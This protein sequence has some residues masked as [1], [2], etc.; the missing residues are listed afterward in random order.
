MADPKI[1][2]GDITYTKIDG[3]WYK[4]TGIGDSRVPIEIQ[5]PSPRTLDEIYQ[6]ET[7]G[8]AVTKTP[9]P[10][11]PAPAPSGAI[12]TTDQVDTFT[13]LIRDNPKGW[14]NFITTIKQTYPEIFG[15]IEPY[16]EE[17]KSKWSA[18][19]LATHL[20]DQEEYKKV[21][22]PDVDPASQTTKDIIILADP[23]KNNF[24][25]QVEAYLGNF[26]KLITRVGNFA[27]N[28]PGEIKEVVGLIGSAAKQFIGQIMNTVTKKLIKWIN[29][30]M[31][32]LTQQIFN[33]ITSP[34]DALAKAVGMQEGLMNP[35][36]ALFKA[37]KCL[38]AK[39]SDAL[40]GVIE[41]MIVSMVKNVLNV[42]TCAVQEF[43]GALTGKI[44]G[45]IDS[46]LG[47]LL[48]PIQSVLGTVF[49][50]R[51]AVLSGINTIR[52]IANLFK[53]GEKR[54]CPT[55]YKYKIDVGILKDRDNEEQKDAL[56]KAL[57]F[58]LSKGASNLI[59]DF[60][61]E[62]GSWS[63]FGGEAPDAADGTLPPCNT[64]NIFKCG[65]PKVEFFGGGGSGVAG[66]V[67]LGNFI[68][69]LDQDDIFGG[70]QKTASIVGVNIT[71]PGEGY[72]EAPFVS[73]SDGCEQ[74]YG[75][76]GRAIIDTNRN[77]PT[78]GEVTS[79]VVFSEGENYPAEDPQD[80]FIDTV[81]IENP[82][83]GYA[84]DDVV[85]NDDVT[86]TFRGGSI[87]R[88]ELKN[89]SAYRSLPELNIRT[90]TGSGAILRPVMTTRRR[91]QTEVARV[92]DCVS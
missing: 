56:D 36:N 44:T 75:A 38:A 62:Y 27:L 78:Y 80:S 30:G 69:K 91:P 57:D 3:E 28:L 9:P 74:G 86:V 10:A 53:C 1:V 45:L 31:L 29:K 34:V 92:I 42:P 73:F 33:T 60:Q 52:K 41:D 13:K 59:G 26:F 18:E 77:S 87:S 24:F 50:V 65:T 20:Q 35:V 89:Q 70:V 88:V 81:V 79:V 17:E 46:A 40:T 82:G 22:K 84:D 16:T 21:P 5:D 8:Q 7:P 58:S 43:I 90:L 76:Y 51:D 11:A 37:I 63:I 2:R 64:G 14:E 54:K 61:N 68:N 15:D 66:E 39:V 48:G 55:T 72:T 67:I 83:S 12:L 19:K 85:E 49:K 4:S 23:C 32:A 47:P 71:Q 6:S 25:A